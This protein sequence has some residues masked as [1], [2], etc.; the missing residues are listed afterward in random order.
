V[1]AGSSVPHPGCLQRRASSATGAAPAD[2]PG[3]GIWS[4]IWLVMAG[5]FLFLFRAE[6]KRNKKKSGMK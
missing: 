4:G 3:S 2:G 5:A 6:K 1:A